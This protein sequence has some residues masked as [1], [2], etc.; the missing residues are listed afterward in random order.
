MNPFEDLVIQASNILDTVE[1]YQFEIGR[2][3]NEIVQTQGYRALEDFSKQIEENCGV[4]RSPASLRLYAYVYKISNQLGLPKD[5]LFSGC[6]E[7]VFSSDPQKYARL[8]K[9]GLSG[10]EIK[11]AIY[12]EKY[13][14][15]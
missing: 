15:S 8:A 7:I 14:E 9:G 13:Q 1:N 10:Y 3:S 5:I 11:K 2:L 12:E 6:R 4:R